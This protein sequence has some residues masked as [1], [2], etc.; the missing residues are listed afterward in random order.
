MRGW[1]AA[2]L[3][4]F[5]S[6]LGIRWGWG[7]EPV[8]WLT[9]FAPLPL[10][11]I[12]LRGPIGRTLFS[13]LVAGVTGYSGLSSYYHELLPPPVVPAVIAG[14]VMLLLAAILFVHWQSRTLPRAWHPWLL[15]LA[16]TSI[17]LL[18]RVLSRNGDASSIAFSQGDRPMV[19]Q[20]AAMTGAGG[21]TFLLT[22]LPGWL[23]ALASGG[24]RKPTALLVPPIVIALAL[25]AGQWR[26]AHAP[27]RE[28]VPVSLVAIDETTPRARDGQGSAR[29]LR[30][31]SAAVAALPV[32]TLVVL[33]EKMLN[34]RPEDL[35]SLDRQLGEIAALHDGPVLAGVAVWAAD[36]ASN[37]ARLYRPLQAP[38][39]YEKEHLVPG[40]ESAF[41]PGTEIVTASI[42]GSTVGLAICRDLFFD[43]PASRYGRL[44]VQILAVPAWDFPPDG[45]FRS[46]TALVRGVEN[47]MAVARSARQGKLTLSDCYGRIIGERPSDGH[48]GAATLTGLLPVAPVKRTPYLREGWL[49]PWICLAL[50]LALI[51]RGIFR[52]AKRN[53]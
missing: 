53:P 51:V 2:C 42:H 16:M 5:L 33:P 17:E 7:L 31:Y 8:W 36:G 44:G 12:A 47:G 52:H 23:A 45:W 20:I 46:R 38:L 50:S 26:L 21:I 37:Q 10:L 48:G 11:L 19:L 22:L 6:G 4:G 3:A 30:A 24:A 49:F 40:F 25:L 29:T 13:V 41:R 39:V 43:T 34:I 28:T 9:W 1:W 15:P 18:L 14:Q 27:I 35:P 32:G